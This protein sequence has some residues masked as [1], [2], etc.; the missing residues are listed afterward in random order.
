MAT[1]T[2]RYEPVIGLEVHLQVLTQSKI[3]CGCNTAFGQEANSQ[4]CPVCLGLPGSLPV[5]NR[6]VVEQGIRMAIATQGQIAPYARFARKNYFYPDLPKG[7]QI[8]MY[9]LPLSEQGFVEIALHGISRKI[10]LIRIHMEEDAGKNLHEG[11]RGASHVDL[12]RAG[13]PLL[14]I[15]STPTI[16]SPEEAVAYLKKL[17]E[18]AVYTGASDADMEKGNFRCD[19]NVSLRPVGSTTFV[20]RTEIKNMNSFRFVQKALEYEIHRQEKILDEGGTVVLETRLWDAKE[21]VTYSMRSKEEAHDYRYFPEPDLVPLQIHS[22]WIEQ[23]RATLPE[24]ADAKRER[25]IRQ[26]AIPEYD[27]VIL[28]SSQ[29]LA[30]FFEK[31]LAA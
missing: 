1:A 6:S 28:T 8:S 11:I 16:R 24:L 4:T 5:L 18:I 14:E 10:D 29:A 20:V 9:E 2:T 12:N 21:G 13:V 26:Y 23:V 3:F 30:N 31:T 17:R 27:A 19:A 15:V 25:F 22:E 7:Y